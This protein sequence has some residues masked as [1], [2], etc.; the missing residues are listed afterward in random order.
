MNF[1][2]EDLQFQSLLKELLVPA[3]FEFAD[4]EL[5]SLVR[6]VQPSLMRGLGLRTGKDNR[7]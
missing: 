5:T 3:F 1:Y 2:K 7:G 4:K 6:N